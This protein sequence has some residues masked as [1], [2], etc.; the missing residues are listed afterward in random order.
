M[1]PFRYLCV[2]S[3]VAVATFMLAQESA[4]AQTQAQTPQ[5][6]QGWKF[7]GSIDGYYTWNFNR[8]PD[9]KN[10]L[11]NFNFN[12]NQFNLNLIEATAEKTAAPLGYRMDL[13][14]GQAADWVN[15]ADPAGGE[16]LKY[17]QQAYFSY[18]PGGGKFQLDFGKYVTQH[19][20]EVIE[21]K[22]NWNY[23]RSLLFAWAIPYYHF[24]FR[25][26]Y[27]LN[28]HVALGAGLSNGWNNVVDNNSG[29][30][31]G[32][33]V[34]LKGSGL[35]YTQNYMVGREQTASD[36]RH[37][38]DSTLIYDA[39]EKVSLKANYDYGMDRVS[40]RRVRWQ[41]IGAYARFS[42]SSWFRVVGAVMP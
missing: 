18:K 2:F 21:S 38:I 30:T 3:I 37:L 40:G 26:T 4:L 23:S 15:A 25:T 19:G 29:K 24:G 22:D 5:F 33:Q 12:H 20:A 41:G 36:T 42:P 14:F 16:F 31:F 10:A 11:Y 1:N 8:P 39:T 9:G 28:D 17:V 32:A 6:L 13:N 35:T 7:G 34:V 27:A